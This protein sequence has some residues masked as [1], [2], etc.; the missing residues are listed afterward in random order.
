MALRTRRS[1][2]TEEDPDLVFVHGILSDRETSWGTPAGP[3]WP[4]IVVNDQSFPSC[5]VA[6]F[7]YHSTKLSGTYSIS[8]AANSLWESLRDAGLIAPGRFPLFVCHS[9]GGLVVR[10]M[11]IQQQAALK[12]AGVACVGVFLVASP[13]LGSRWAKVFYP[14]FRLFRHTQG[15]ALSNSELNGWLQDLRDDFVKL[16]D[17]GD[18]KVVGKELVEHHP[19]RLMRG[20][21]VPHIVRRREATEFFPDHLV[22]AGTDHATIAAPADASAEQHVAL[23]LFVGDYL[24]HVPVMQFGIPAGSSFQATAQVL[25]DHCGLFVDFQGFTH[26]ELQASS[27][28]DRNVSGRSATALLKSARD[29]LPVRDVRPYGVTI[30]GTTATLSVR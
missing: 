17:H 16:R 5:G 28:N 6:T 26:A 25:A 11:L 7:E 10:R 20:V 4:S 27:P 23:R 22:I 8:D 13:S 12:R 24:R 3:S 19:Y 29:N 1:R 9:M 14:L 21:Y 18:I 2:P 15:M 30:V